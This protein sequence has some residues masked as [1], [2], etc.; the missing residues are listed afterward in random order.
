MTCSLHTSCIYIYNYYIYIYL[1]IHKSVHLLI[2]IH[3]YNPNTVSIYQSIHWPF[4]LPFIQFTLHSFIH[5]SIHP[6]I[7]YPFI[8]SSTYSFIYV[9]QLEVN[10]SPTMER[11][12]TVTKKLCKQVMEDTIK[13]NYWVLLINYLFIIVCVCV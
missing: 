10:C 11:N 12:T 7:H 3:M 9:Y 2:H 8:H 13:G 1:F 6:F 5:L 4:R